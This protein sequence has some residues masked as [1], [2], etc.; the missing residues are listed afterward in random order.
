MALIFLWNKQD[1][2][3]PQMSLYFFVHTM[4]IMGQFFFLFMKL[5]LL[6]KHCGDYASRTKKEKN[7]K[8]DREGGGG[9]DEEERRRRRTTK[10][11]EKEDR[12]GEEGTRKKRSRKFKKKIYMYTHTPHHTHTQHTHITILI[13]KIQYWY[14]CYLNSFSNVKL[15]SFFGQQM[16]I[17]ICHCNFCLIVEVH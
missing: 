15:K 2:F 5:Q 1:F 7:N 6:A 14:N 4:K 12:E 9:G 11:R 17:S 16:V 3:C 13:L 10:N 8:K